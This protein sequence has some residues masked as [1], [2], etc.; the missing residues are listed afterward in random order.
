MCRKYFGVQIKKFQ[1]K[2]PNPN[3]ICVCLWIVYSHFIAMKEINAEIEIAV[4]LFENYEW[5]L[6]A[7]DA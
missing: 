4:H 2:I 5:A 1:F 7:V 6:Y 3:P